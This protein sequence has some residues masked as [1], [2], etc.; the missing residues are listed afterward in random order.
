MPLSESLNAQALRELRETKCAVC[1]AAK[2]SGESFCKACY[3]TLPGVKRRALYAPMSD[4]YGTIY[5]EAKAW[6]KIEGGRGE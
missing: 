1:G 4:G 6:L 5:D 3:F 2:K